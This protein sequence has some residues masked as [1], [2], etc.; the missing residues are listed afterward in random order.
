[1]RVIKL[2]D[3]LEESFTRLYR[4]KVTGGTGVSKTNKEKI[5]KSL[6]KVW[7][8][9]KSKGGGEVERAEEFVARGGDYGIKYQIARRN[10]KSGRHRDYLFLYIDKKMN[11]KAHQK[12]GRD[13]KLGSL[14]N[15]NKVYDVLRNWSDENL[16]FD[17]QHGYD[18]KTNRKKR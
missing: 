7:K 6:D 12:R 16:F 15:V 3:L 14:N 1:M 17:K 9:L 13:F 18:P 8:K 4:L 10:P 2:Q 5:H 11:V